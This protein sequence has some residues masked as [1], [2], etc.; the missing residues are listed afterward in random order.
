MCARE[1][2]CYIAALS[3]P[4]PGMVSRDV[5]AIPRGRAGLATYARQLVKCDVDES[6]CHIVNLCICGLQC[7]PD[8]SHGFRR[9]P[10]YF[11]IAVMILFA[12]LAGDSLHSES[13]SIILTQKPEPG[14]G[15]NC[16]VGR[17]RRILNT[18]IQNTK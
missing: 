14:N 15:Q 12:L 7:G 5:C 6:P 11:V 10:G 13:I 2:E 9:G 17:G 8:I 18:E 1:R 4:T 3:P 16:S